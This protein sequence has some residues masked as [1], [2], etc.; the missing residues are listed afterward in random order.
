MLASFRQWFGA[1][2]V[3]PDRPDST[4]FFTMTLPGGKTILMDP[5][6]GRD[7]IVL[8][9]ER[10][11]WDEFERPLPGIIRACAETHPKGVI[12]DVGANTGFYALIA[13]RAAPRARVLA[14]EPFPLAFETLSRNI[15]ANAGV[16]IR[17]VPMAVSDRNGEATLYVPTQEHGLVETSSS[18]EEGFRSDYGSTQAVPI[19]TLDTYLSNERLAGERVTM[20]KADVE[21]HEAAVIAGARATI[22]RWRPLL[23]LEVLPHGDARAMTSFLAEERYEDVPIR[24]GVKL[25]V[26]PRVEHH[27]DA[28]NHALVPAEHLDRFLKLAGSLT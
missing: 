15:A 23:F 16:R 22:A 13:S 10:S 7:Q 27:W 20:I 6:N 3:S 17:A 4:G 28:W 24:A 1:A 11:S 12:V 26:E 9:A 5:V 19:T 18:L 8:M 25:R 2:G 21:G 14:F